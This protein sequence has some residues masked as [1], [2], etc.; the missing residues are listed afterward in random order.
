MEF[1]MDLKQIGYVIGDKFYIIKKIDDTWSTLKEATHLQKL[2]SYF[3]IL[4]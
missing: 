2:L 3:L 4:N 1:K